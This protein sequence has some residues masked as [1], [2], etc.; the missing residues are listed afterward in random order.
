VT[1]PS[2]RASAKIR[3]VL[4]AQPDMAPVSDKV[5]NW[6]D[7]SRHPLQPGLPESGMASSGGLYVGLL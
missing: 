4:D 1:R 7:F 2:L 6:V 5:W 3:A